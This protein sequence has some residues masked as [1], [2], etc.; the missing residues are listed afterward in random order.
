MARRWDGRT[1][2]QTETGSAY[3]AM[4]FRFYSVAMAGS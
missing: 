4:A 3:S 1:V 2:R